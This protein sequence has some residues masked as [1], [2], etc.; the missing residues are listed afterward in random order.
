MLYAVAGL[1]AKRTSLLKHYHSGHVS[2]M[3]EVVGY[4][5]V[6]VQI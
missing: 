6:A 2:P 4:A 5:S 3:K 1:G